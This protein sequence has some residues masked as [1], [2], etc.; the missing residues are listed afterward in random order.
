MILL[1]L[2]CTE[3]PKDVEA[4]DHPLQGESAEDFSL[5]DANAT[6]ATYDAEVSVSDQRGDVSAW[7]F[8]HAT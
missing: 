8:G 3:A 7:Y 5:L 6:S 2:A 1:M 4:Y